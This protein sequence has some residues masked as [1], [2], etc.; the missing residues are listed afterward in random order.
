[1]RLSS[2]LPLGCAYTTSSIRAEQVVG[3]RAV[4]LVERLLLLLLLLLLILVL[5]LHELGDAAR[6]R[7]QRVVHDNF[8]DHHEVVRVVAEHLHGAL[9]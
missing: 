6:P 7:E 2:S 3:I 4:V 1:V 5:S 9:T 8:Q